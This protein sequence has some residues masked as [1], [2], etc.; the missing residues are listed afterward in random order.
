MVK[1]ISCKITNSELCSDAWENVASPDLPD[2]LYVAQSNMIVEGTISVYA[3]G[4]FDAAEEEDTD[5]VKVNDIVSKFALEKIEIGKKDFKI[6]FLGHVKAV[7]KQLKLKK[8]AKETDEGLEKFEKFQQNVKSVLNFYLKN[9]NDCDIYM[10][11]DQNAEGA[12]VVGW[13]NPNSKV[14]D[15]PQMCYWLDGCDF[16]KL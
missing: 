5:A 11:E 13:W 8:I 7:M 2:G 16:R 9:F 6:M 4:A 10:N 1:V 3:A 14:T 15:A 12:Y